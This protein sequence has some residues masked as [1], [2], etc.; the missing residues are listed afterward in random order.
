M[1][2]QSGCTHGRG[3]V[4]G[5][6]TPEHFRF[7]TIVAVDAE[8]MRPDGWRAVCI[9]ARITEGG[10]GATDVCRFEV[11]VPIRNI[12][13]SEVPLEVAQQVATYLANMAAQEILSNA[14]QGEMIAI[15]CRR[16]KNKYEH[17]LRENIAGA[18]VSECT[19]RGLDPVYF[20]IPLKG[21]A[22]D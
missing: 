2:G 16:F 13:Q 22:N 20:D 12:Q 9:H 18:R 1:V 10:S 14:Q 17:L 21:E 8:E 3:L 11:G 6:I 4:I 19:T 5:R 7:K 15:L